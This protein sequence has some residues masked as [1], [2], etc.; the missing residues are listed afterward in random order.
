VLLEREVKSEGASPEVW[1]TEV[2]PPRWPEAPK[3]SAR[4]MSGGA[5]ALEVE[6]ILGMCL[7][8]QQLLK[9]R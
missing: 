2:M 9:K 4:A 3:S 8:L 6:D 7:A 5:E 1:V